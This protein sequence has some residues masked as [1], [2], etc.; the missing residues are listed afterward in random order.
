MYPRDTLAVDG[1]LLQK[2][3][4]RATC[5]RMSTRIVT[6]IYN[7]QSLHFS[8]QLHLLHVASS[9]FGVVLPIVYTPTHVGCHVPAL[10]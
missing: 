4:G 10:F 6:Y 3:T 1:A 5:T 9:C 8:P 7:M 2:N